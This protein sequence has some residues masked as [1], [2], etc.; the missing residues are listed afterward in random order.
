MADGPTFEE[1][2]HRMQEEHQNDIVHITNWMRD[3]KLHQHSWPVFVSPP[4][5]ISLLV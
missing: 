4:L 2:F 1:A 3:G 5:D